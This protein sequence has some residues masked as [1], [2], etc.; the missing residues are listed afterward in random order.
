MG[1]H[2]KNGWGFIY[3]ATLK[4]GV[5][6]KWF[7]EMSRLTEWFAHTDSDRIIFGVMASLLCIFDI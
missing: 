7:D 4:S 2:G 1:G 6:Q 3:N 5:S